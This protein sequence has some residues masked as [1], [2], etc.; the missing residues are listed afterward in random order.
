M[1]R[2]GAPGIVVRITWCARA[3]SRARVSLRF[4]MEEISRRSQHTG[5][6]QGHGEKLQSGHCLYKDRCGRWI[7]EWMKSKDVQERAKA[8]R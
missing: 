5:H 2:G 3:F 4:L 8:F 1:I 7:N 6:A